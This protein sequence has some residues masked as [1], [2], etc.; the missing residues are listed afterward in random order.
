MFVDKKEEKTPAAAVPTLKCVI[1]KR[2]NDYDL[3]KN[4]SAT[5]MCRKCLR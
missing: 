3:T 2:K 5:M 1:R 4:T